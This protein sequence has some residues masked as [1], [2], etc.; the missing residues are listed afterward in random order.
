ML[1]SD[2]FTIEENGHV[3]PSVEAVEAE[4]EDAEDREETDFQHFLS[5]LLFFIYY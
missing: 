5:K 1:K 2:M 3:K 4:L